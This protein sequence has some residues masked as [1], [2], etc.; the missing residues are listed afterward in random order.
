MEVR[1]YPNYLI[2][3]DGRV[4]NKKYK[5]F[6]EIQTDK[7][8]YQI[9]QLSY[10][11]IKRSL[12]VHRLV[13]SHYISNP[14]NKPQVD[15][16]YRDKTDNRVENLRWVTAKENN[17]NK[18]LRKDNKLKHTN[19]CIQ[20]KNVNDVEYI[21]YRYHKTYNEKSFVK[22]FKTLKE[23]LCYKYIFTLKM[24]AGLV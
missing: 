4:Y 9:V 3:P 6:K 17:E 16:I 20:K 24:R 14:E 8:G 1:G 21:Y 23:A 2:Y 12:S 11:N 10:K 15:H 18:G 5:R 22:Y 13:A 19:I 7:K